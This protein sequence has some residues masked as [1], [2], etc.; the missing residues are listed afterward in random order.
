MLHKVLKGE[1]FH[2]FGSLN[3]AAIWF[4]LK[5]YRSLPNHRYVYPDDFTYVYIFVS[6]VIKGSN[7]L[8]Q[9][10]PY[11]TTC[12]GGIYSKSQLGIV[13]IHIFTSS[14]WWIVCIMYKNFSYTLRFCWLI[15][16]RNHDTRGTTDTTLP[17]FICVILTF[18]LQVVLYCIV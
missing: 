14:W 3:A 15:K 1:I 6:Q 11:G 7:L 17:A 10:T 4:T 18:V 8:S 2:H 13:T 12:L 16:T 9:R 5:L